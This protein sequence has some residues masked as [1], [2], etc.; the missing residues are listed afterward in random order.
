LDAEDQGERKCPDPLHAFS[1]QL[2]EC[3]LL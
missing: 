1:L 3:H 2:I